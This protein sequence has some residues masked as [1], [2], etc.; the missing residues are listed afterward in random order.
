MAARLTQEDREAL[1]GF[2][3]F[4]EV[5]A[6]LVFEMIK[7]YVL[8]HDPEGW[9]ADIAAADFLVEL[10]IVPDLHP[11]RRQNQVLFRELSKISGAFLAKITA[12]VGR[13]G[14]WRELKA[15]FAPVCP[16]ARLPLLPSKSLLYALFIVEYWGGA[17]RNRLDFYRLIGYEAALNGE[18][19]RFFEGADIHDAA[20]LAENTYRA[21]R[22]LPA[23]PAEAPIPA[24][25]PAPVPVP[26]ANPAPAPAPLL[27]GVAAENV[28]HMLPDTAGEAKPDP[29]VIY[30]RHQ[31]EER[32]A[33]IVALSEEL[34]R[35]KA[36]NSDKADGV[37]PDPDS[38]D[39]G[40]F[41]QLGREKQQNEV[42]DK[43]SREMQEEKV[44]HA[45]TKEVLTVVQKQL[46]AKEVENVA[47]KEGYEMSI[48]LQKMK[49]EE[50]KK[51]LET[52]KRRLSE[53]EHEGLLPQQG[54]QQRARTD[55]RPE[56]VV[57]LDK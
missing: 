19:P 30:L 38:V 17:S 16:T 31:L 18:N 11:A 32:D 22:A 54:A 2:N 44:V 15:G 48:K 26:A 49:F 28:N 53:L 33:K 39:R 47:A 46:E 40:P 55:A 12:I 14:T 10:A 9:D 29:V 5:F 25:V 42:I 35:V 43:L 21:P 50:M 56:H 34:G 37:K 24:P 8:E 57:V 45:K 7:K 1:I 3:P 36:S 23:L 13:G 27:A 41:E 51:E 20:W 6:R 52:T 4:H